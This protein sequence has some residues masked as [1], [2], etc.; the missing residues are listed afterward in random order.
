MK[1]PKLHFTS[2]AL[3][4]NLDVKIRHFLLLFSQK[5]YYLV[6]VN[7]SQARKATIIHL[8]QCMAVNYGIVCTAKEKKGWDEG[9]AENKGNDVGEK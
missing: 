5:G 4:W 7:A 1:D 3:E 6:Q 2:W 8:L 9:G